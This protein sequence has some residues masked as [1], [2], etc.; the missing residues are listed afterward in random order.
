MWKIKNTSNH[1]AHLIL[2]KDTSKE[3]NLTLLS[4]N[5]NIEELYL[6]VNEEGVF[7][8]K[9]SI[10]A[11][12]GEY[13]CYYKIKDSNGNYYKIDG[14]ENIWI[15]I[16]VKDIFMKIGKLATGQTKSYVD[17]DDGYYQKG[18]SRSY[19]RE[20]GIVTYQ[21][22]GLQWQDDY[23]D[24]N[25]SVKKATWKEAKTYCENLTLGGYSDWRLPSEEELKSIV[26]YGRYKPA[27]DPIF[28]NVV[29]SGYW[30]G[31]GGYAAP[32]VFFNY[33]Y[34]IDIKFMC[35]VSVIIIND[36]N[37]DIL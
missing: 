10:P 33:G 37:F 9:Y 29:S 36:L 12:K 4:P 13:E 25:G 2:E 7:L 28:Q 27:I 24:N 20:N 35:V 11:Q 1:F 18:L 6:N 34:I 8:L 3:C 16:K 21:V 5:D 26:D 14:N 15:K 30:A 32:A 31:D 22:T 17:Y 19:T 23:S